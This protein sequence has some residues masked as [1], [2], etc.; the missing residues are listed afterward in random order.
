MVV[1]P[2]ESTD[3]AAV[4]SLLSANQLPIA[5]LASCLPTMIVARHEERVVGAAGLEL[6]PD[7][8]LLRSVVVNPDFRG[9]ALGQRLT[10]AVLRLAEQRGAGQVFLL[11]TTAEQFFPRFGFETIDREQVPPFVRTSVEFT[12]ACPTTA[13]VMWKRLVSEAHN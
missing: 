1:E 11:T 5:G 13:T 3:F 9:Q 7:G 12:S 6:Y 2:A 4:E 8:A 10:E